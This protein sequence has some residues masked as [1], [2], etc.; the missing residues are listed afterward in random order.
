MVY[1]LQSLYYEMEQTKDKPAHV[2]GSFALEVPI[3][4]SH[5]QPS[6]VIT[7]KNSQTLHDGVKQHQV[8]EELLAWR[9]PQLLGASRTFL[10]SPSLLWEHL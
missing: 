7:L 2:Q 4:Q 3:P 9:Q 5:E 10:R 1:R 6:T 8:A